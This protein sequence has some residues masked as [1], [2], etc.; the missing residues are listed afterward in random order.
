MGKK[1]L[2]IYALLEALRASPVLTIKE[3]AERFDV[4]EMT[5]RRDLDYLK[6]NRLLYERQNP[7]KTREEE[8]IYSEEQIKHLNKKRRIAQFAQSL[9]RPDD[10]LILD[11]GTTTGELSRYIPQDFP[12]TVICYNFHILLQLYKQDNLSLIFAGGHFHKR[13]LMFESKESVDLIKRIRASKMFVSASGIHEKLGLTC[14]YPHET[15]TKQAAIDSALTK[16]LIADSSKFGQVKPGYFAPLSDMDVIIT[17]T[18]LPEEWRER[19]ASQGIVLH[20]V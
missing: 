7:G 6:E 8:Y 3:L 15:A 13:D 4:S 1:D 2:R 10:I 20:L 14:A 11:S 16:I 9:I 19:I 18:D 17:N 5:I 12:L